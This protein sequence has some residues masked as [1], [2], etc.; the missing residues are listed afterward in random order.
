MK[1]LMFAVLV[2]CSMLA[3]G[4]EAPKTAPAV[5][6]AKAEKRMAREAKTLGITVEEY[7]K[8]SP[9]ELK[10]KLEEARAERMAKKYGMTVDEY[11]K[12]TPEQCKAKDAEWKAAKKAERE[13]KKAER[14]KAKAAKAA[15]AKA[16]APAESK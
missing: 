14:A 11:R 13:A 2:G 1:K 4:Q 5:D 8:L 16:K 6:P 9:D 12:L 10:T 15:A 7:K 3:F